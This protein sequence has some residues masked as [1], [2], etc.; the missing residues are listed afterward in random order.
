MN[1]KILSVTN[2]LIK[3]TGVADYSYTN[4]EVGSS[5]GTIKDILDALY[6]VGVEVK[7]CF[8]ELAGCSPLVLQ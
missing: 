4:D 1:Y 6:D 8:G 7:L 3:T 5:S 2:M